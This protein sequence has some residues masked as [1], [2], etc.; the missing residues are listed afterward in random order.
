MEKNTKVNVKSTGEESVNWIDLA[1]D[2]TGG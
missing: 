2:R 1:Y